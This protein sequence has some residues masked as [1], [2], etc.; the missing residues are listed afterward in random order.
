MFK[1]EVK[2]AMIDYTPTYDR[3]QQKD[4][5]V[6]VDFFCTL[7]VRDKEGIQEALQSIIHPYS[8]RDIFV[9]LEEVNGCTYLFVYKGET[10]QSEPFVFFKDF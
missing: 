3:I 9:S 4:G 1:T 10:Y 7:T 6:R 2:K 8:C 5:V